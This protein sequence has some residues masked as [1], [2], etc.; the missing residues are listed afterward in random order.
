ME[1]FKKY[2]II[3]MKKKYYFFSSSFE[4]K[5]IKIGGEKGYEIKL[6]Y[7]GKYLKEIENNKNIIN[8]EIPES[9]FKKQL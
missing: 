5:E 9:E 3:Q 2:H 4:I 1:I 6:L 7:L 8:K